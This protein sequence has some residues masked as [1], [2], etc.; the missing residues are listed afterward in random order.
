MTFCIRFRSESPYLKRV[1][2]AL[3]ANPSLTFKEPLLWPST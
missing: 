3:R 2:F 1:L